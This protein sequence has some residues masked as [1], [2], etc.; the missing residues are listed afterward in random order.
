MSLNRL[1]LFLLPIL[2]CGL[3]AAVVAQ[4]PAA[5]APRVAPARIN[6]DSL[7][8]A[9]Q[10]TLDSARRSR[11]ALAAARAAV[12]KARADSLARIKKY[13]ESR[14]Y[15]DSVAR[16]RADRSAAIR[17]IAQARLDSVKAVRK[18]TTDS[19]IAAREAVMAPVRAA[20]KAR[21][22]SLAAVRSYRASRRYADSVAV[23]KK[24]RADSIAT[25]RK[26]ALAQ[27][28]A[29]RKAT[30]EAIAAARKQSLDSL[31]AIRTAFADSV[32][33]VRK[34]RTDSLAA[35]K[36]ERDRAA[37]ARQ[38][39][40][41]NK[42][43]LAIELRIKKKRQAWSNEQMLKKRWGLPRQILQNTFTRYNY[44][45]NADRKMDEALENM[46]R[47]R[48]ENYDS[49]L[50]LFPFDPDR[51]STALKPDMDSIIQKASVGIQIHDPR[52]KWGD[53]L[54]LL[55]GQAYY[56]KGDY[57]NAASAFRYILSLR[58]LDKKRKERER[59][60][61]QRGT[62]SRNR[63]QPSIVEAEKDGP[64]DFLKHQAVHNEALLWLARVYTESN[65]FGEAESVLDLLRSDPAFPPSLQARYA[66]ERGNLTLAGRNP[67]GAAPDLT[68]VA[69]D[70]DMPN[71]LRQR[72]AYIAGQLQ[73]SQGQYAAAVA[74][75]R[76]VIDLHPRV[77]M[78]FY[79]RRNL[80]YALMESGG[81][82]IEAI[83]SLRA[84][85]K[86]GKFTPYYDQVYYVLGRL[87]ANS[88]RSDD[89]INYLQQAIALPRAA[90][91]QKAQAFAALGDVLYTTGAYE[92]AKLAYDSA[93][94]LGGRTSTDPAIARAA[95]RAKSL[96]AVA[97]PARTIREGDSLL[98][99][100]ALSERDQRTAARRYIRSLERAREDSAARAEAPPAP[101]MAAV[102]ASSAATADPL[103]GDWY[104]ASATQVQQGAMEFRRRWGNRPLTDNWRRASA[105]QFAGAGGV[106][107]GGTA[108]ID[109]GEPERIA[110]L[111]ER[112]IPTEAALLAAIPTT[113][114]RQDAMRAQIQRA[115][116]DLGTAYVRQL[117]D[118]P[119][120][121]GSLDTLDRRY[122]AHAHGAEVLYLRYLAALRQDKPDAAQRFA[123]QLLQNYASSSWAAQV[124]PS[125]PAADGAAAA[126]ASAELGAFYDETYALMQDR[127][128][129][130]LLQRSREGQRR[131]ASPRFADRFRI[132]EAVALAGSGDYNT[133]DSLINAFMASTP[134]D[135]LRPWAESVREYIQRTKPA[136]VASAAP[137]A[138]GTTPATVPT[139]P[140]A[141]GATMPAPAPEG[142][143]QPVAT[144]TD[145]PAAF[146]AAPNAEHYVVI[147]I[148]KME[149]RA[150]GLKVGLADFN[151]FR[152]AA[153]K[154]S[155]EIEMLSAQQGL[156]VTR[157][158]PNAAAAKIYANSA[159][160][161]AQL[162]REYNAGE[163]RIFLITATNY[164][165][166]VADRSIQ[167][168]LDFYGKNYR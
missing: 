164:K 21:T 100:A 138:A 74:S 85:L 45:F 157:A 38:K 119:R 39:E 106:R 151:T 10:A 29:A 81:E 83:A 110:G 48:R 116:V 25:S 162:F 61:R 128:Y 147:S 27:A 130:E 69:G 82:Q 9:R 44:Y 142:T 75:F 67:R 126:V 92:R 125:E 139:P 118:Y 59:A 93:S 62:A 137:G 150:A 134:S 168:Y 127:R 13:R 96:D 136:P 115:Y 161:T 23:V 107:N 19:A 159:R 153:R 26:E 70:G 113:A 52:T 16:V 105:L 18:A 4:T 114:A 17:A 140:P 103:A 146:A 101:V 148:P 144:P 122:T 68:T 32:K 131:W 12:Q 104:F 167:P 129:P 46:L 50:A 117:E 30:A 132:M 79:A 8:A 40:R 65:R 35:R 33:A 80:A 51:D 97:G 84:L 36:A 165:K 64:L 56:Y 135:S 43:N 121:T 73:A 156:V 31:K 108:S 141:P 15:T 149:P 37:K 11:E 60:Q 47:M 94:I 66:L 111:D 2:L 54:Y 22:D 28:T 120:A 5:P 158:F 163:Y 42:M 24:A 90:R 49:L 133:A 63:Q 3:P 58:E 124:R 102:D 166:L 123:N 98:A 154:L 53:D 155:T 6:T 109:P 112:G 152:F 143:V 76:K 91:R 99:L 55:L 41:E 7:R 88:G 95:L 34:V 57:D 89:A 20:Q 77:E 86:D 72:A 1:V 87:S 160:S 145:A 14:R 78:E 71:W